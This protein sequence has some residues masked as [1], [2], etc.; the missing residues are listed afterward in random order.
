MSGFSPKV[1]A[2]TVAA[3]AATVVGGI[4]GPYVFPHGTPADVKGLWLAV[5]TAGV[6]FASGYFTKHPAVTKE[7]EKVASIADEL[8]KPF[9]Q[10]AEWTE[11]AKETVSAVVE[12]TPFVAPQAPAAPPAPVIYPP[13]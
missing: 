12:P 6:T 10:I 11:P 5:V 9:A 8:G 1:T 3:S 7:V 4:V 2:S 13:Q